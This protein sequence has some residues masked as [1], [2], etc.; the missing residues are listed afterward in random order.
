MLKATT[1]VPQ[2]EVV[3]Q[4]A[5]VMNGKTQIGRVAQRELGSPREGAQ[6]QR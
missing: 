4:V 1:G 3:V 6:A 5:G 2:A